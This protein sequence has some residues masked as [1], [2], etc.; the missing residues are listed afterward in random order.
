MNSRY[1]ANKSVVNL[2]FH[3]R[4]LEQTNVEGRFGGEGGRGL[5]YASP[6]KFWNF[7]PQK[8]FFHY[9]ENLLLQIATA[10]L[11]QTATSVITKCDRYYKVRQFYYK[12]RQNTVVLSDYCCR[13]RSPTVCSCTHSNREGW[14]MRLIDFS[15]FLINAAISSLRCIPSMLK[16]FEHKILL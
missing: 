2:W 3:I 1:L 11:L 4:E 12:V 16:F 10:F 9:T 6:E 15:R 7:S 14:L 5:R 8:C 13:F